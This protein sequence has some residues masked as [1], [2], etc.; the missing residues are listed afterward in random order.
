[1]MRNR[2]VTLAASAAVLLIAGI[3]LST[4]RASQQGDLGGGSMFT[5][6]TPE[7]GNVTEVRLSKGDGSR[8]TLRKGAEGWT[9]VER[10]Y[11]ADASRVRE[12]VLGLV[13]M[14]IVERKTD[15]PANYGRLGVEAPDSP[16]AASTLVEVVAG[17][18]TWSLIAGKSAEGRAIYVRKPGEK[19]SLL[20]QP[21]ITVDPDQKRWIDRQLTD[22]PGANVHDI[23]VKPASGPAYLLARAKRGD[24][25]LVMSPIPKGRSAASAMSIDAQADALTAF[26]FDDVRALPA[27]QTAPTDH[28]TYRTFDGQVFEIAG[29]R[30][31][32]KAL[33]TITASRDP[34]LAAQF[35]AAAA[36]AVPAPAA[37]KATPATPDKTADQPKAADASAERLAARAKSVEYEVPLYKYES[38]F[39]AQEELLEKKPEPVAKTPPPAKPI[40]AK[41]IPAKA[42]PAVNSAAKP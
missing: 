26:N 16:T 37:V 41:S 40:P 20:A 10:Q 28:A 11:P 35:P 30:D 4:H 36:A 27:A 23:S 14:K 12:L 2:S 8:T 34:V 18:K 1:M 21:S 22:I 24:A 13:S 38:I 33:V 17:K 3:W 19:V 15:D 9:V 7:L 32:Q 31:G 6:L 29:R 42:K 25:D 5:D 39:K